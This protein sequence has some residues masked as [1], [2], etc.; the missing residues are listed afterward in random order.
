MRMRTLRPSLPLGLLSLLLAFCAAPRDASAKPLPAVFENTEVI[1]TVE[2]G[3]STTYVS[4]SITAAALEDEDAHV[5]ILR[6]AVG[7]H[8][9]RCAPSCSIYVYL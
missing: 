9:S 6:E 1:R 7:E 3:G 8:A 4:T 5:G 2:L